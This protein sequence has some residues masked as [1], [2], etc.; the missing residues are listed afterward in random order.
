MEQ[1]VPIVACI[2]LPAGGAIHQGADTVAQL[3]GSE[4]AQCTLAPAGSFAGEPELSKQLP[5][6]EL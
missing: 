3:R 6:G 1:Y 2:A 4:R 5:R